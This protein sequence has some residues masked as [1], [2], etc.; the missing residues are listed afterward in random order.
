MQNIY[1]GLIALDNLILEEIGARNIG[2]ES[3]EGKVM[4]K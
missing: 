1:L 3:L 4:E 2:E